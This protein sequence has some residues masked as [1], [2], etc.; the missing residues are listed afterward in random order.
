[1]Q[2]CKA[3]RQVRY[4]Q[5]SCQKVDWAQH[6][7]ECSMLQKATSEHTL[8]SVI[9]DYASRLLIRLFSQRIKDKGVPN[10]NSLEG[11]PNEHK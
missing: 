7:H 11:F 6:K 4:C 3:C 1:M 2:H 9:A 5:K 10:E 8:D